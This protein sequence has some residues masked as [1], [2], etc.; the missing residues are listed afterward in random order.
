MPTYK[1]TKTGKWYCQF[2]LKDWT[3]K[4]R[5]ITKR[6]FERKKDAEKYEADM[7]R[8]TLS[9]KVSMPKLISD[10]EEHLLM[11]AK[12]GAIK[13]ST[14]FAHRN[15]IKY[16]I[17]DYFAEVKD[18]S[19]LKP[20][21]IN[22]W[23]EHQSVY[24]S[25]SGDQEFF[26]N[27]KPVPK[28]RSSSTI[29]NARNTL[30]QIFE[31]AIDNYGF[32]KNPVEK[33]STLKPFSN[34]TRADFWTIEQYNTFYF[35]LK[36]IR[37]KILFNILYWSGLRIGEALALTPN[38]ITPYKISVNKGISR[39]SD[40]ETKID[41][42]KTETSIRS[43]E[44]PR[45]LYF[46]IQEYIAKLYGI[47]SN[48]H[49]F[50]VSDACVRR[51]LNSTAKRC[52]LPRISPHI[53]RH[54]YASILYNQTKDAM[55]VAKQI[56]HKDASVTLQVYSHMLPEEDRKAIDD[57]ETIAFARSEVINHSSKNER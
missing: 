36:D 54:S 27:G 23:L 33:S 17:Y 28:K 24:Q 11:K 1:D 4:N 44:I 41:T 42:P 52:G 16:Y 57:L 31:F 51:M 53:L 43:V 12:V 45:N 14:A 9:D 13:E 22:K 25:P 34:D 19:L 7:K 49:I 15:N 30:N 8:N 39:I 21:D 56:G 37:Y 26:K 2:W 32:E 38:D 50:S 10:F 40:T 29:R 55:V 6:G 20:K 47:T 46:Q 48:D 35:A 5:H 3:G 18:A